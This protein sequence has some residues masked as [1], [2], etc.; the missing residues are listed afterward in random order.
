MSFKYEYNIN[1]DFPNQD[2][3]L[4]TFENE[5]EAQ[6]LPL[7]YTNVTGNNC[8]VYCTEELDAGQQTTLDGVVAAHQAESV[9]EETAPLLIAPTPDTN[10]PFWLNPNDSMLY[11]YDS[12]RSAWL[13]THRDLYSFARRGQADGM[14]LPPLGDLDSS[15]D[16]Y[17]SERPATI[18]NVFCR[19]TSGDDDKEFEIRANGTTI[20]SFSYDGTG[21]MVYRSSNLNIELSVYDKLQVYVSKTGGKVYNTLCRIETAWRYDN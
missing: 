15:D 9:E 20:H 14:Y 21:D 1:N 17:M 2:V 3:D 16:V 18:V 10:S 7:D 4:E 6:G 19:S 13:S 5:V 11:V 12:S 8:D